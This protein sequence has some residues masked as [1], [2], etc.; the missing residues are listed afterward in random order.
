MTIS[1]D[2][3]LSDDAEAGGTQCVP[4][5]SVVGWCA[6]ETTPTHREDGEAG[7][8]AAQA[9]MRT[10]GGA[11]AVPELRGES[12]ASTLGAC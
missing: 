12:F 11:G 2:A 4:P 8:G 1:D 9:M 3:E 7:Q 10:G 5:A 6:A